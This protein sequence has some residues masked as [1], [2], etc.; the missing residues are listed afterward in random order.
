MTLLTRINLL[1]A[2]PAVALAVATAMM[3]SAPAW[4]AK[5]AVIA[6]HYSRSL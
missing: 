1:T 5:D 4:A 3:A 2:K 6:V